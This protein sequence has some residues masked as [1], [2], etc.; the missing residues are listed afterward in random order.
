MGLFRDFM[1][2]FSG[3]MKFGRDASHTLLDED[4]TLQAV[5]DATCWDDLSNA[6]IA[7]R[8]DTSSGRLDYDYFNGGVNFNSNARYPDEP[9]VIP[10][11]F[12]HKQLYGTGAVLR[13]HFHW[14]QQQSAR[15]NMLLGY[16]KTNYGSTTTFETDFTNYTLL[17]PDSDVFT[18]TGGTLA[19]I[20]RFPEID[21]SDVTISGSVDF[22]LFRDSAN[23]SGL[24]AGSDPVA[25]DVT[26]KYNDSHAKFDMLGSREEF[27][28]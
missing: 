27:T 19:Q 8:L 3:A 12:P 5:G 25:S 24:F 9:V 22:A 6:I 17:A 7:A 16:K 20:T 1:T 10:I 28:K 11:Q 26:I 14:L 21:V 18:Y 2:S 13:P 15:P 23:A 4:G